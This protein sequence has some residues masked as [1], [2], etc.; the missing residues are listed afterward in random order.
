[1]D[2]IGFAL[3]FLNAGDY[4]PITFLNTKKGANYV[5]KEGAFWRMMTFIPN[6]T[7]YNTTTNTNIAFEAGRIVGKFHSLLE[8]VDAN[9]FKDTLPKFHNLS[10]R[11]EE[12]ELALKTA[13]S[14]KLETA[15]NA[16]QKA[17]G[18]LRELNHLDNEKLPVRICH[19][20]TKLNNI[21]FSK[22][23][24]KALCLID[25]DTIMKGY[26]YFDFGDAIRTVVNT[27][28]EDE[29]DHKKIVFNEG[30]FMAFVDGLAKNPSFLKDAEKESLPLGAIFMPF[31]HG[32]RALTDY[33]NNNNY[34]KVSY[35]KQNFDRCLSL[36]NFAEKAL[37][38]KEMMASY[39]QQKI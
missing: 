38:K 15:K 39:I 7:T 26:F 5:Q 31:I 3:P 17:Y 20:D 6:S 19:N 1:M 9:L 10:H 8:P 34:Y 27:A 13:N 12:I 32:L 14:Q 21:L 18:F 28:P 22:T 29:Q 30:L 36:F 24:D 23:T 33:L 35:E 16:I 2:N 11:T 4:T 37:Q 25:L